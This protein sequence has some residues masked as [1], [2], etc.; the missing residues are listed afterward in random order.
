MGLRLGKPIYVE[1]TETLQRQIASG[2]YP[3]GSTLPPEMTLCE[4]HSVSRFTARAALAALQRQGLVSRRPRIGSVVMAS[5]PQGSY[6]VQTNSASDILRFTSTSDLHLVST[7]DVV[8][9]TMLARELGGEVGE[10]W[11]K[12]S[13][14][15]DSPDTKVV[16]SWTDFYLRPEH[17]SVVPLIGNKR[18]SVWQFLSELQQRPIDRIE[19]TVE[20]CK[21]PKE[22]AVVLGVAPKSPALRAVY[23]LYAEGL[24]EVYYVA[25]SLYPEG[26][27]KLSQTLRRER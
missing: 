12:V 7:E 1:L 20:A 14:F 15:R 8:A 25:I 24:S 13:T 6:S 4:I 21:L 3:V 17:R 26:R 18:G 16:A 2:E 27:F 11:I 19:Q 10:L 5:N 9:D 23:R 22:A